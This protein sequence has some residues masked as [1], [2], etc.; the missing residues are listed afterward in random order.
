MSRARFIDLCWTNVSAHHA[1]LKP[2][3]AQA[4]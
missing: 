4:L 2:D 1:L 3:S